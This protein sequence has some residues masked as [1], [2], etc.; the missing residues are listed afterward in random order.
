MI[1]FSFS[2]LYCNS[3]FILFFYIFLIFLL[4]PGKN[5]TIDAAPRIQ[6]SLPPPEIAVNLNDISYIENQLDEDEIVSF[7]VL[8]K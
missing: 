4:I 6:L 2:T 7:N 8:Q 5:L 1:F 3:F